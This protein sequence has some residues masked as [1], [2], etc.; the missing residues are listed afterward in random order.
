M[1]VTYK[2][3]IV[4]LKDKFADQRILDKDGYLTSSM[5][6]A[7]RYKSIEHV[8]ESILE[9]DEPD[10]FEIVDVNITYEY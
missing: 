4:M 5:Q 9:L 2:E 1:K 3:F 8:L 10:E 7:K 6:L